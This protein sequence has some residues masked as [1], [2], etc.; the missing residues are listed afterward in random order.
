MSV[1]LKRLKHHWKTQD[2]N[3]LWTIF[4]KLAISRVCISIK[5]LRFC[6][7]LKSI[8]Q[9]QKIE[10]NT[11]CANAQIFLSFFKFSKF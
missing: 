7:I 6:Y 10:E 1:A 11:T 5:I 2:T 4:R 8:L 3:N 9:H